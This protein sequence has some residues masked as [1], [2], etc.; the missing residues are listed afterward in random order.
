MIHPQ[1]RAIQ[2]YNKELTRLDLNNMASLIANNEHMII[3]PASN[4]PKR[5][6]CYLKYNNIQFKVLY[7]RFQKSIKIITIYP[8]D[9]DEYNKLEE[10]KEVGGA[11]DYFIREALKLFNLEE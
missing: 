4:N 9:P 8:F 10:I 2:R 1:E 11:E 3:G 5:I 6:F 7:Q